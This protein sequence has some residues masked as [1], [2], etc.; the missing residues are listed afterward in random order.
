[1]QY[2]YFNKSTS[3]SPRP[4]IFSFIFLAKCWPYLLLYALG[5]V[6][7]ANLHDLGFMPGCY[8]TYVRRVLSSQQTVFYPNSSSCHFN[9]EISNLVPRVFLQLLLVLS[10]QL[11][12]VLWDVYPSAF[13]SVSAPPQLGVLPL[14]SGCW[15]Q[16]G[17]NLGYEKTSSFKESQ[18]CGSEKAMAPHSS[19]LAWKTPWMGE[20]G[21]LPSM[22]SHRVG[23][24]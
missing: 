13:F 14:S 8:I 20:P 19:T 18:G 10:G 16:S 11:L 17:G 7:V 6:L 22:G 24:D 21:G 12:Q 5:G 3:T 15:T 2:I 1:M 9:L 23:H 4:C